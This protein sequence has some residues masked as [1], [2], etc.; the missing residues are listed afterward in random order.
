MTVTDA[1]AVAS[2]SEGHRVA[3]REDEQPGETV[4]KISEG[5]PKG[6]ERLQ[7]FMRSPATV[8]DDFFKALARETDRDH[9]ISVGVLQLHGLSTRPAVSAVQWDD[10]WKTRAYNYR[11]REDRGVKPNGFDQADSERLKD[12]EAAEYV[13]IL[14]GEEPNRAGFICCPLPDHDERTP[15]FRARGTSWRCYGCSRGGSIYDLAAAL[16]DLPLRGSA[17]LDL[18]RQLMERF[19]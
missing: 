6:A 8:Q 4:P 12:I 1:A 11:L 9:L 16:W 2:P 14:T 7:A 3:A 17:F 18:H 15:S 10:R 19:G 5:H 13:E